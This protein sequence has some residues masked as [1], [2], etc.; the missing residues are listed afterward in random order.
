[1]KDQELLVAIIDVLKKGYRHD[2]LGSLPQVTP[3]HPNP[4][5]S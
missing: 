4:K 3:S 5:F 2:V 1:M